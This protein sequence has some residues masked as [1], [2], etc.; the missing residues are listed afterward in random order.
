MIAAA[1]NARA[2]TQY[3]GHSSIEITFYRYG[4][5]MPGNAAEAVATIDAYLDRA[6]ILARLAAL[7]VLPE[8]FLGSA[9]E[10]ETKED[11]CA[12]PAPVSTRNVDFL[13]LLRTERVLTPVS[14]NPHSKR[15]CMTGTEGEGFEPSTSLTTRNGFRDRAERAHSQGL[16]FVRQCVRQ[17]Q[18]IVA[19][20]CEAST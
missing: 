14:A 3:L 19:G 6:N 16:C 17:P 5:L 20:A 9:A 18:D 10:S 7:E 15:V 12:G 11:P 1:V 4:H 13:G 8:R 2:I